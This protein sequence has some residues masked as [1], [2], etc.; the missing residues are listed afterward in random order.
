MWGDP[1]PCHPEAIDTIAERR[2]R[3][4]S[5]RLYF[6]DIGRDWFQVD[7]RRVSKIFR[8]Q[9]ALGNL[10]RHSWIHQYC[11]FYPPAVSSQVFC[12]RQHVC[13]VPANELGR[14]RCRSCQ[15]RQ[16]LLERI[17]MGVMDVIMKM[18]ACLR[19]HVINCSKTWLS[20]NLI[21]LSAYR[22]ISLLNSCSPYL[23][24]KE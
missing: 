10:R 16:A 1:W 9:E 23:T 22:I 17:P 11:E 4:G 13:P 21:Q 12:M 2:P 20:L 24:A 7:S 8:C 6:S 14:D 15:D 19:I 3:V 18:N 5:I